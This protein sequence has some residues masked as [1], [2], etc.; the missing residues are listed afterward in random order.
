MIF[1]SAGNNE[2]SFL[3]LFLKFEKI[4]GNL[5][6]RNVEVICQTGHTEYRNKNFKII[7]FVEKKKFNELILKSSVFISHAGAG[8]VIDSI[9]NRKIPI[10]LPREKKFNE[11]VDD[12]QVELY[13][14]LISINLASSIDQIK[15]FRNSKFNRKI[16]KTKLIF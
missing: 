10:L 3:R 7:K 12:H 9:Q 8:S 15:K 6:K 4:F 13:K 5:N 16:K 2:L 11:H 1:L 14:K